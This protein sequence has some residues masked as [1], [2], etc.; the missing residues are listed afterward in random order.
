MESELSFDPTQT[1]D[2]IEPS[3]TEEATAKEQRIAIRKE[4]SRDFKGSATRDELM[5]RLGKIIVTGEEKIPPASVNSYLGQIF[6]EM[7]LDYYYKFVKK[8]EFAEENKTLA[9]LI[10]QI[11]YDPRLRTVDYYEGRG[12]VSLLN[13]RD[14][15]PSPD[16]S[17]QEVTLEDNKWVVKTADRQVQTKD[18]IVEALNDD[19]N[20]EVTLMPGWKPAS[21]PDALVVEVVNDPETGRRV[22]KIKGFLDAKISGHYT[23]K[24]K[25]GVRVSLS[26][27]MRSL[28]PH[29]KDITAKLDLA[30]VLPEDIDVVPAE[31]M[32]VGAI[33]PMEKD[34]WKETNS[35]DEMGRI[36]VP[37]TE[38]D[39]RNEFFEMVNKIK[40]QR[41]RNK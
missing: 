7:A 26:K 39:L 8:S 12:G 23:V 18:E 40:R 11:L 9:F 41:A 22:A 21:S 5:E 2:K 17:V 27:L 1:K 15:Q 31:K 32:T 33:K 6:E 25:E 36:L 30:D 38:N 3:N 10:Q 29:Y 34:E 13:E 14:I 4:L 20:S 35:V 37:V 19:L 24:Q 16:T 28:K